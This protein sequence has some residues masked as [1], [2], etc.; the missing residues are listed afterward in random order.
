MKSDESEI[1][2][3]PCMPV[4]ADTDDSLADLRRRLRARRPNV[5]QGARQACSPTGDGSPV[6]LSAALAGL[7]ATTSFRTDHCEL[8]WTRVCDYVPA[9]E[10]TRRL[11]TPGHAPPPLDLG[12]VAFLD[13]ETTGLGSASL[14]LAGLLT[15]DGPTATLVQWFARDYSEE[16][17]IVRAVAEALAQATLLMTF[18]GA[19]FDIPFLRMRAAFHRTKI[20]IP[21][22]IDLLYPARRLWRG[23]LPDCK[24]QTIER[25][26]MQVYR[27]DDIP[28]ADVPQ[29]YHDYVRTGDAR[30][31]VRILKHNAEDLYTLIQIAAA[32]QEDIS[33]E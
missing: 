24:L 27:T 31:V 11:R 23:I 6:D 21:D 19:S 9:S 26:I 17:A 12:R 22:H 15:V 8:T 1:Q 14:F 10:A 2:S 30:K 25:Q 5:V 29:A 18:N 33:G 7:E 4:S 32:L 3:P 16:C 20:R 13:L 28:G